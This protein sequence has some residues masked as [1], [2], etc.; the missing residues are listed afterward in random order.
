ML[1]DL[2]DKV[3]IVTGA[4]KTSGI[5]YGI[6][7]ELA[8]QGAAVVVADLEA[9]PDDAAVATGTL[10]QL[11]AIAAELGQAH[12]VRTLAVGLDVTDRASVDAMAARV[13]EVFGGV[14][15]LVNNAG[16]TFG[17]PSLTHMYDEDAWLR[18][19]DVNLHGVLRVSQA[20]L[21]LMFGREASIVNIASRAGKVPP[22]WNGAYAVAKAGVIMLSKVMAQ[23]LG[24]M[25]VRV[26]A[27]CPG[28]IRTDLEA[29]RFGLEAQA[30]GITVEEREAEMC[31]TI[32]L[33]RIGDP[34]DVARQVAFLASSASSYVTGQALNVGGGQTMEL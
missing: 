5:G 4:G 19:M 17:V 12:G 34:D 3:A 21:P 25:N 8:R 28:Q 27:V 14:D 10:A 2:K 18:T 1:D 31:A 20:I 29:W 22:K 23:E 13:A 11:E 33:A 15:V 16:A 32:P 30:A 9:Q 26:N 6:A 24:A 7:R